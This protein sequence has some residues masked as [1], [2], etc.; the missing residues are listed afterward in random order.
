[1]IARAWTAEASGPNVA[2]YVRHVQDVVLPELASIPGH[3]GAYLLQRDVG[4][5]VEFMVLTLWESMEAVERFAGKTLDRAV[6][7]PAAQA[8]LEKYDTT[9][10]HYQIVQS[11]IPLT[12]A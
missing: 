9:V 10:R 4:A 7:A 2:A 8:L 6:I 12:G 3:V 11:T 5:R 1:M